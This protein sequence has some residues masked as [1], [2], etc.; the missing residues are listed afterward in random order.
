MQLI[1]RYFPTPFLTFYHGTTQNQ[2][3]RVDTLDTVLDSIRWY[4]IVQVGMGQ[5]KAFT[6]TN[7]VFVLVA[8]SAQQSCLKYKQ[9]TLILQLE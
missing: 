5:F 6:D 7:D 2:V 9:T 4:S 8:Y 3:V 1:P